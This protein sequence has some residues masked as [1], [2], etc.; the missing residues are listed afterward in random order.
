MDKKP[1]VNK[2][3]DQKEKP[4]FLKRIGYGFISGIPAGFLLW[5][6]GSAAQSTIAVLPANTG[7]VGFV[8]GL[9]CAVGIQWG[10]A[11]WE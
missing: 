7:D 6:V 8:I 11:L 2:M 5:I 4:K 10:K 3:A 9:A 1:K